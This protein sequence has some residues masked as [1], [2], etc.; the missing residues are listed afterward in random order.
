MGLRVW[1]RVLRWINSSHLLRASVAIELSLACCLRADNLHAEAGCE[2]SASALCKAGV[3]CPFFRFMV[4]LVRRLV[5]GAANEV[6]S[7]PVLP[8]A[9]IGRMCHLVRSR[10]VLAQDGASSLLARGRSRRS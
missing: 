7:V 9:Q 2:E 6:L 10:F 4:I 8:P 5:W 3:S 1:L